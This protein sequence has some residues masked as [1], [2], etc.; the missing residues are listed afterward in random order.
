MSATCRH[1]EFPLDLVDNDVVHACDPEEMFM[2]GAAALAGLLGMA[3]AIRKRYV[4]C[5]GC[6]N[7]GCYRRGIYWEC[8]R[9]RRNFQ[10]GPGPW[11]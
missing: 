2:R 1:C 8:G 7:L 11:M 6:E 4:Q 5:P 3:E 10:P 9:C